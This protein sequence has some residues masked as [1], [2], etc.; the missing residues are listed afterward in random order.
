[1][2]YVMARLSKSY[3]NHDWLVL[4]TI[5]SLDEI[6]GLKNLTNLGVLWLHNCNFTLVKFPKLTALKVLE[7]ISKEVKIQDIKDKFPNLEIL[8]HNSQFVDL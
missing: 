1:M 5:K 6:S 4:D 8:K 2:D 7:I 3:P